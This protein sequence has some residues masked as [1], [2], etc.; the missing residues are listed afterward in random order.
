MNVSF[1]DLLNQFN[2][3]RTNALAESSKKT[4]RNGRE[5]YELYC[6][7]LN[8]PQVPWPATV[9]LIGTFLQ[10][11]L[12]NG[13]TFS[14]LKILLSSIA[15][16]NRTN[17]LPNFCYSY[18]LK[19][20]MFASSRML[21]AGK[22]P[23][24]SD[25]MKL[26]AFENLFLVLD[27]DNPLDARDGSILSIQFHAMLRISE[28]LSIKIEDIKRYTDK[29]IISITKTKTDQ[30]GIGR[31]ITIWFSKKPSNVMKWLDAWTLHLATQR[32]FEGYLFRSMAKNGVIKLTL[33]C[34][35]SSTVSRRLKNIIT[36]A[37]LDASFFSSH[38]LRKGGAQTAALNG[39]TIGTI[40]RTG[41][42]KSS[43]FLKYI[44]VD[45]QQAAEDLKGKF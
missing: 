33:P 21:L 27:L 5:E 8:P 36:D 45:D 43:V 23:Y 2:L 1:N 20:F 29:I 35:S 38:S 11:K 37:G 39:A 44:A 4:Y 7:L 22:Y 16:F 9:E 24:A 10:W 30:T 32:I 19:E 41:G 42:W 31:D 34:I 6:S 17:N 28:V 15:N 25:A 14:Y 26:E 3:Q 40:Q 18:Q 12:N 13:C